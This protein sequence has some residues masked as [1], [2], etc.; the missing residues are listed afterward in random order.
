MTATGWDD[1]LETGENILWQGCPAIHFRIRIGHVFT[2]LF[3]L[4]FAGFALFW[5]IMAAQ[6]GGGFWMFGLLHFF[7]G[8]GL[9][10]GTPFYD[11]YRRQHTWYTLTNRRAFIATD[12]PLAGRKIKSFPINTGT[13][14]DYRETD[15]PSIF[16]AH[17]YRQS[18]NGSRR[19]EIGFYGIHD[20][21]DVLSLMRGIQK[22]AI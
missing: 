22:G 9:A 16:F 19:I 21:A 11:R 6:A 15:P 7:V 1:I 4:A 20:G 13:V 10:F 8:L 3:G 12:L 5:M 17:E 18:K 2:V 14:L